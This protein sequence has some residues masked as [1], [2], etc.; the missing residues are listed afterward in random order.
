MNEPSEIISASSDG[1]LPE[2]FAVDGNRYIYMSMLHLAE[3]GN[4]LDP[5][6]IMNVYTDEGAKGAIEELGGID[7]LEGIKLQPVAGNTKL[8]TDQIKQASACRAVY[9][10]AE[11]TMKQAIKAVDTPLN[12]FLQTVEGDY[13]E[14]SLEYQVAQGVKKLGSGIGDRLKQR[15]LNPQ[16]VIG[17]K[18]GWHAFDLASQ[19]LVVGELTIVGARSKV[20]KSTTL[21]NWCKKICVEDNIPTLYIDT[22]MYDHEQEDKLLSIIS[23]VQH[24]EIRNGY[25]AK[26]TSYGTGAEK[27]K[28]VAEASKAISKAP[29]Y[30]IYLPNFTLGEIA[31]IVRKHQIEHGIQLVVFD[32]IKLPSS[33]ANL[34]D[35][36]W[37]ALGYLTSGLKD[38]AGL[39]QIPIASA[40]QLGRGAIAKKDEMDEGDIAGSDRIL[41]LANRVC[42]LRKST[43][44]EEAI[45]GATHQFKIMAQRMG[46]AMDWSPIYTEEG[47]WRQT[48]RGV[49]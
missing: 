6:S 15:A 39:L 38:L 30:H 2:M 27:A 31:S 9:D 23:G 13:R 29:F 41:Q 48:M 26:N 19:G 18:T 46:R 8:F 5:I 16:D 7:Y 1:L 11:K 24:H 42:F 45:Q 47:N 14:I 3:Q 35:K 33:N 22:E 21:L 34:G 32:Y 37:Q 44:E 49:A 40:V 10:Q 25:F 4:T 28:A 20:G 12:E 17:L 43:E 36:E